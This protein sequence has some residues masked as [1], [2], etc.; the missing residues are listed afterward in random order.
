MENGGL[1]RGGYLFSKTLMW[2]II[3]ED[4]WDSS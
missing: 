2:E 1:G 4:K 3:K